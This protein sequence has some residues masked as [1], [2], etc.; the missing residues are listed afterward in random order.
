M[1]TSFVQRRSYR[2]HFPPDSPTLCPLFGEDY[3][4]SLQGLT[5]SFQDEIFLLMQFIFSSLS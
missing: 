1:W 4:I 5:T 2:N 3:P